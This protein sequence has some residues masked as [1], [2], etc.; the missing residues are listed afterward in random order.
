MKN[1]VTRIDLFRNSI[2]N[3][4]NEGNDWLGEMTNLRELFYGQTNFEYDGIPPAIGRLSNLVEYDCSFTLYFGPLV[5]STF[6]GLQSLG[7]TLSF[8]CL[9]LDYTVP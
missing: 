8:T 3:T 7:K 6:S 1:T 4:G 9:N 5:G 2:Y